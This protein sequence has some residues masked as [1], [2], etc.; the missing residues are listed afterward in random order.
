[1]LNGRLELGGVDIEPL[2]EKVLGAFCARTQ[3]RLDSHAREEALAYLVSEAWRLSTHVYDASKG[4]PLE[5]YLRRLLYV[6]MVDWMRL[7]LGRSKWQFSDRVHTRERPHVSSLDAA[8]GEDGG[9][10]GDAI[11]APPGHREGHGDPGALARILRDGGGRRAWAD[12]EDG[13]AV[14]RRAA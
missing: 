11:A 13:E 1:M 10:A 5:L 12:V 4:V 9:T 7:H 14:P 6:R 2:A 3:T 8:H